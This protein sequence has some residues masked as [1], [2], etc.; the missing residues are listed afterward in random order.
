MAI[1]V[2]TPQVALHK[3][4]NGVR[5]I[6]NK[7]IHNNPKLV[8]VD[9]K[10]FYG[11]QPT[12]V[13]RRFDLTLSDLSYLP[14]VEN[15]RADW[16]VTAALNAF[17]AYQEGNF[18]VVKHFATVGTGSGTDVIAALDIFPSLAS[19]TLTD[20]H[21]EV[22]RVAKSNVL[23]ATEKAGQKTWSIAQRTVARSGD[24]LLPL[25]GEKQF[26]LIYEN[27]P[28]IPL[29]DSSS[30]QNGQTSSTYVG[31][32]SA[33]KIPSSVSSALLELHYVC[34]VQAKAFGLIS[35]RGAVLS[36]IGGRVAL[37][38]ILDLADKAGY[39]GRILTVSW[40][41]Q[42]E[43]E[44]V[45]GGYVESEQKEN[46]E[47]YF[48]PTTVLQSVFNNRTPAGAG[49][50]AFQIEEELLPHRL[51]AIEA[52]GK[53]RQGTS[54]GHTVVVMASTPKSN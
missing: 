51:S 34:L 28:N 24:L 54:I 35:P 6:K 17:R 16:V 3:P 22:V 21:E 43:P 18:D 9:F 53:Y 48:Y 25:R 7:E 4:F 26:D 27:L 11:I 45:I 52:L 23:A 49:L 29:P 5:E 47:F 2:E 36:S 20:M 31:D 30:L 46:R 39:S 12:N 33:D 32:R 10:D 50:C 15:P 41:E 38:E 14:K 42:S 8:H 1:Q 13:D 44:S 40:K 19:V 37:K